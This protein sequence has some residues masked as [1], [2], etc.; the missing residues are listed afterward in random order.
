MRSLGSHQAHAVLIL[1]IKLSNS[2]V[3]GCQRHVPIRTL[4][5]LG[6]PLSYFARR[7]PTLVTIF[8]TGR[9]R[10]QQFINTYKS[11]LDIKDAKKTRKPECLSPHIPFT[12]NQKRH[13]ANHNTQH[14]L[15]PLPPSQLPLYQRQLPTCLS[16]HR[17]VLL[18]PTHQVRNH[19]ANRPIG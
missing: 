2:L 13:A 9:P 10:S 1:V 5:N 7:P 11:L 6:L 17:R 12:K 18:R 16:R 14:A 3:F 8:Y 4:R 15:P 19:V